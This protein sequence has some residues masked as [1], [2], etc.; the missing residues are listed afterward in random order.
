[1]SERSKARSPG[2][3]LEDLLTSRFLPKTWAARIWSADELP[4]RLQQCTENLLPDAE[5]R[6]YGEQDQIFFAIAR[7]HATEPLEASATALDAYFL[8]SNAVVYAAGVWQH[9]RQNGWWLDA[10]MDLTYDCDRGWWPESAMLRTS[11]DQIRAALP[12][13]REIR[14][15]SGPRLCAEAVRLPATRSVR[16]RR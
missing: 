2:A 14:M 15:L 9:T 8:D 10:L 4:V 12:A 1:M 5:W 13:G 11:T 7:R 3:C 6:A 16:A